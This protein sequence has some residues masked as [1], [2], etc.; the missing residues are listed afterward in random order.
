MNLATII[1]IQ[2]LVN[3]TFHDFQNNGNNLKVHPY[4]EEILKFNLR[5]ICMYMG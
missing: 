3:Y 4:V 2:N 1:I 5:Y